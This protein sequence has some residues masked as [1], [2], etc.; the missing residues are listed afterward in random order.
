MFEKNL[1]KLKKYFL[2]QKP[3]SLKANFRSKVCLL[4]KV[5]SL[6]LLFVCLITFV[7]KKIIFFSAAAGHSCGYSCI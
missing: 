1:Q 2:Y 4:L 3:Q 7:Y 6:Y 5:L